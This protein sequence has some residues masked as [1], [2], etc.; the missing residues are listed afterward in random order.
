M[1][2]IDKREAAVSFAITQV[3]E[4]AWMDEVYAKAIKSNMCIVHNL[5][6]LFFIKY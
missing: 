1:T 5:A 2:I 6:V 3:M 4:D